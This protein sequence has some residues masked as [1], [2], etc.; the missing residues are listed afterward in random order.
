MGDETYNFIY[1]FMGSGIELVGKIIAFY[2][3]R[4]W[5]RFLFMQKVQE[6]DL[7]FSKLSSNANNKN[8]D[9][10]NGWS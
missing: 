7:N 8:Q 2:L 4:L 3:F 1:R 9:Q 5:A 6:S 10:T